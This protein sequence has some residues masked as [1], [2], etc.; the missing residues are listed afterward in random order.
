[1]VFMC[2]GLRY[3]VDVIVDWFDL[4]VDVDVMSE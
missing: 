1:M 2:G 4:F 3:G